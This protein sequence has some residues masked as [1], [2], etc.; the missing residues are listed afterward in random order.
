MATYLQRLVLGI[1]LLVTA[2]GCSMQPLLQRAFPL[3]YED[4]IGYHANLWALDPYLVTAVIAVESSFRPDAVSPRGAQGLM[5]LMPQTA[6]WVATQLHH[7]VEHDDVFDPAV[8]IALGTWYLHYLRT[9]LPTA[10]SWLA[11]YNAGQGNVR[12][13]LEN[14]TWDGTM[15]SLQEI[16]FAET[17]RYLRRVFYTWE[18]YQSIYPETW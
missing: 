1:L 3:Y 5:Q 7:S 18:F 14:G 17:R 11:A 16:P 4:L 15:A 13:W 2:T 8:N 12:R 10:A 6:D 9:Q